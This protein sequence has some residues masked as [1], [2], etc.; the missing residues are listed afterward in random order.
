VVRAL[1]VGAAAVGLAALPYKLF[2][3]DRFFVPKEVVLQVA[4]AAAALAAARL[5]RPRGGDAGHRDGRLSAADVALALFLAASAASALIAPSGWL[6]ARAVG[7][8]VAGVTLFWAA[9]AAA[10]AGRTTAVLRATALL[11]LVAVATALAQAYGP[12]ASTSASTA[13]RAAR[14]ATATSWRTCAP[15][16]CRCWPT[17]RCG[18]AAPPRRRS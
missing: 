1:W 9:R 3:L 14:S 15:S 6:A 11:P 8:S 4:A 12:R 17:W 5:T 10:R 18:R 7:V 2:E 16:A 13:R